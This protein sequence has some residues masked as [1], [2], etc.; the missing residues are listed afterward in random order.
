MSLVAQVEVT[1][2]GKPA[3]Y[4]GL[5]VHFARQLQKPIYFVKALSG[6]RKGPDPK[7]PQRQVNL[8][9]GWKKLALA[10]RNNPKLLDQHYE[11][12]YRSAECRIEYGRVKKNKKA[13]ESAYKEIGNAI[14]NDPELGG[15]IW[16]EKL[17]KLRAEAKRLM[18]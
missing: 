1:R 14:N 6:D 11:A 8:I 17:L 10:T 2:I 18:E 9:W 4:R 13:F 12:V 7:H 3:Y 15:G 5:Y 16:K